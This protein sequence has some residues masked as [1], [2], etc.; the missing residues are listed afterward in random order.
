MKKT[1]HLSLMWDV[2][3]KKKKQASVQQLKM[4]QWEFYTTLSDLKKT[5]TM[6]IWN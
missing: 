4:S 3:K 5:K 6:N 1:E 2:K